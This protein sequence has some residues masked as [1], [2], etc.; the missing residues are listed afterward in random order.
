MDKRDKGGKFAAGNSGGPGRPK[1]ETEVAYL[2]VMLE[3]VPLDTWREIVR[4]VVKRAKSGDAKAIAWLSG[5]VIG[6]PKADAI[7]PSRIDDAEVDAEQSAILTS[8]RRE[9]L[10]PPK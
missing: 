1:R 2:R 5:Y 10:S 4:N 9:M 3:E 8:L 7:R 6:L